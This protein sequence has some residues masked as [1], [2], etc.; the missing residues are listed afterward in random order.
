MQISGKVKEILRVIRESSVFFLHMQSS[1]P[2]FFFFCY[3]FRNH[4]QSH[5]YSLLNIIRR[6]DL[7]T[8]KSWSYIGGVYMLCMFLIET[9]IC[10]QA[11]H[12]NGS[13]YPD[14][15]PCLLFF[16][17]CPDQDVYEQ[18]EL[19][20]T[21]WFYRYLFWPSWALDWPLPH[22]CACLISTTLFLHPKSTPSEALA[23]VFPSPWNCQPSFPLFW[24]PLVSTTCSSHYEASLQY[25]ITLHIFSWIPTSPHSGTLGGT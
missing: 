17:L 2:A 7:I 15:S 24:M 8:S 25:M 14:Q 21:D 22:R 12:S 11:S 18:I 3:I 13:L 19:F 16:R 23:Q 4:P 10:H 20:C 5:Q 9:A 6:E 1:T